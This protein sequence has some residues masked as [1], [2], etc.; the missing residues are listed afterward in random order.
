[1]SLPTCI[2]VIGCLSKLFLFD[3]AKLMAYKSFMECY[4]KLK[5]SATMQS[6][7]PVNVDAVC[8]TH[9]EL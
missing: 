3:F 7:N 4:T 1:M 2:C 9:E 5:F 8:L 6:T